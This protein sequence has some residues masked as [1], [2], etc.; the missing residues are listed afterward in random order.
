[1]VKKLKC[2]LCTKKIK[3]KGIVKVRPFTAVKVSC[4]QDHGKPTIRDTNQQQI[5]LPV[6]TK[7]LKTERKASQIAKSI[8][9][10]SISM[11]KNG[12]MIT[13]SGIVRRLDELN[14]KAAE[15]VNSRFDLTCKQRGLPYISHGETVDPNKH[16]KESNLHL[17]SCGIKVFTENFSNF[18]S[19]PN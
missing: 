10:L 3:R 8:T 11:K 16:F 13:V 19:K 18:L 17:N 4:M 9:D 1:M 14:N 6:G 12:N 15:E 2:Y 7:D 5:I